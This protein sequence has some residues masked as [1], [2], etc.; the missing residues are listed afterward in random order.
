MRFYESLEEGPRKKIMREQW[1]STEKCKIE[2]R[3]MSS[4]NVLIVK[5]LQSEY[6]IADSYLSRNKCDTP[7]GLNTL[8]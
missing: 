2:M 6:D 3:G 7:S 4:L 8:R 1:R 5:H